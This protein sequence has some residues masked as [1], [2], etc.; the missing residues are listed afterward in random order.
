MICTSC[1]KEVFG[2]GRFCS[3]CAAPLGA[4]SPQAESSATNAPR[5]SL[6]GVGSSGTSTPTIGRALVRSAAR[7]TPTKTPDALTTSRRSWWRSTAGDGIPLC[8]PMHTAHLRCSG[9]CGY[10]TTYVHCTTDGGVIGSVNLEFRP[11]LSNVLIHNCTFVFLNLISVALLVCIGWSCYLFWDAYTHR[12]LYPQSYLTRWAG[13]AF[14]GIALLLAW[15]RWI[16]GMSRRRLVAVPSHIRF[17]GHGSGRD[18][19]V[20]R[21]RIRQVAGRDSRDRRSGD[22][23]HE[24]R[25]GSLRGSSLLPELCDSSRSCP[26]SGRELSRALRPRESPPSGGSSGISTPTIGRA[27][28]RTAAHF[29]PTRTRNALLMTRRSWWLSIPGS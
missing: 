21:L 7:I 27:I 19:A 14:L 8:F 12:T 26:D 17:R 4:S 18:E 25:Q 11:R 15:C 3:H 23:L 6:A 10:A 2:G 20:T 29:T 1:G 9:N 22:D 5:E 24:L 13:F 16:W 28:A